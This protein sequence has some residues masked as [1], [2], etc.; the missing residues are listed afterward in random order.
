M[1]WWQA[2]TRARQMAERT[3]RRWYV[4]G[5][6]DGPGNPNWRYVAS[7]QMK[8]GAQLTLECL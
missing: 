2:Y 5:V 6:T 7:G 3:G 4:Y 8:S 1:T